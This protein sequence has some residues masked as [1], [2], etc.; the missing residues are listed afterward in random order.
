MPKEMFRDEFNGKRYTS[1]DETGAGVVQP[2]TYRWLRLGW[3][4]FGGV[5]LAV[6]TAPDQ[7]PTENASSEDELAV[8]R[9]AEDDLDC[10]SD[11]V[12]LS[13][14]E[15]NRLIEKLRKARDQAFGRDA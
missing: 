7:P 3:D 4:R 5:S 9:S 2:A 1:V 6:I 14:A 13:R 12:W 8:R 11:N 10:T 15:I